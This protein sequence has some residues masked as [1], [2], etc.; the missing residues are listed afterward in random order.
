MGPEPGGRNGRSYVLRYFGYVDNNKT[1]CATSLF[2]LWTFSQAI[3][4]VV[5]G[6]RNSN[7]FHS[8][9]DTPLLFIFKVLSCHVVAL[10]IMTMIQE[11]YFPFVA[12]MLDKSREAGEEELTVDILSLAPEPRATPRGFHHGF[13]ND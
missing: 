1:H 10:L 6:F 12:A 7:D 2:S 8:L 13:K 3:R 11:W 4:Y 5:F 9:H